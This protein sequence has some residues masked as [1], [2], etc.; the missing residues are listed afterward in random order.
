MRI[1]DVGVLK[2]ANTPISFVR[3]RV[4]EGSIPMKQPSIASESVCARIP[5]VGVG[6]EGTIKFNKQYGI[7][8]IRERVDARA[9]L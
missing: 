2:S 6:V 9:W 3:A 1:P 5:D 4:P 7:I 8:T